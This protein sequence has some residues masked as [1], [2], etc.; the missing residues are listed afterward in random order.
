M[1]AGLIVGGKS[2]GEIRNSDVL[3]PGTAHLRSETFENSLF[4]QK[5]LINKQPSLLIEA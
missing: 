2:F 1:V 3:N 4:R 5:K